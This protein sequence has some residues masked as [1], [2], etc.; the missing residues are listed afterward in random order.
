ME[1]PDF[2]GLEG[3]ETELMSYEESDW[4]GTVIRIACWEFTDD[5]TQRCQAEWW[6]LDG[7]SIAF[8]IRIIGGL[9]YLAGAVLCLVNLAMTWARRPAPSAAARPRPPRRSWDPRP[10]GPSRWRRGR[11]R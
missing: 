6:L 5:R 8:T 3:L 2:L 9:L 11:P 4:D 10:S 7:E 1:E